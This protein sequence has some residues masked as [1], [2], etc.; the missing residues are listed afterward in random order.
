[1]RVGI[2]R[3]F[4]EKGLND[5]VSWCDSWVRE[6]AQNSSDCG[7]ATI[8]FAFSLTPDGDTLAVAEND[9]PPMDEETLL[10]KFLCLGGTTKDTTEV[11]GSSFECRRK[12]CETRQH[13]AP[14]KYTPQRST[15][16]RQRSRH[17]AEERRFRRCEAAVGDD[18]VAR[19]KTACP[20]EPTD[21][22]PGAVS[23]SP[24]TRSATIPKGPFGNTAQRIVGISSA[25]G[26]QQWCRRTFENSRPP[27]TFGN[28]RF[29]TEAD[30]EFTPY[31]C[32][33]NPGISSTGVA[34]QYSTVPFILAHT[35]PFPFGKRMLF[36]L[37]YPL[38]M[39]PSVQRSL[40]ARI[41]SLRQG[42]LSQATCHLVSMR[43]RSAKFRSRAT[44]LV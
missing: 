27:R 4:F 11:T 41:G 7:A 40:L 18:T 8:K 9:G 32:D 29:P 28:R 2:S 14:T 16:R 21:C 37:L 31:G 20:P 42:L 26:S 3:E 25:P 10:G 34:F 39:T 43:S 15:G 30:W 19:R 22:V 1:M 36:E 24:P 44:H 17:P 38:S 13:H 5:Y 33:L 12:Y 35:M 6:T 23:L